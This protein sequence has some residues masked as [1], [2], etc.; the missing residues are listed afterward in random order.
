MRPELLTPRG[1]VNPGLVRDVLELVEVKVSLSAAETWTPLELALAYDWAMREHLAA[2]DNPVKFRAKPSFVEAAEK[3]LADQAPPSTPGRGPHI[4]QAVREIIAGRSAMG[5]TLRFVSYKLAERGLYPSREIL[6]RWLEAD[7]QDELVEQASQGRWKATE[8]LDPMLS[9]SRRFPPEGEEAPG[10]YM[11]NW[12]RWIGTL[13]G[14]QQPISQDLAITIGAAQ[15]A[16]AEVRREPPER[17]QIAILNAADTARLRAWLA[18][19][20]GSFTTGRATLESVA[21]GGI[22]VRVRPHEAGSG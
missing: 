13:E 3:S 10:R 22:M 9:L 4:H 2:S 5:A 21:G 19:P 15:A 20:N 8:K 1:D 16:I 11:Q 17:E 7:E 6:Q 18:K 14:S 12:T